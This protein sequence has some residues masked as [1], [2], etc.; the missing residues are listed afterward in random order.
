METPIVEQS[1]PA[2]QRLRIAVV[3]ETFPPEINGVAMTIGRMVVGLHQRGHAIQLVRPKQSAQDRP[4]TGAGF[5]VVRVRGV[6]IPRYAGLKLGLPAKR[7]LLRLW[8]KWRPDVVHVVT[9]GPLGWSA[10]A[11]ARRLN[12]PVTSDFHTNFHSYSRHYGIGWLQR[13]IAGYL[14]AFHNRADVTFVPTAALVRELSATG[15][16]HLKVIARGVDTAQFR[17]ERRSRELRAAWGV[18]DDGFAVIHVG[19]I[20]AEKNL[21]LLLRAFAAI[22]ERRPDARLILVGDGPARA[23]L[24]NTAPQ[25][26][27]AGMRIGGDL[28]E[29]YASGDLFLFP[30][31]TETYGNVVTEAM[32]SGL[33]VVAFDCAAAAEL[34]QPGTNGV[35]AP[36]GV[37]CAFVDAAAAVAADRELIARLGANARQRVATLDWEHINEAFAAALAQVVRTHER[38]L[39]AR[40]SF[41]MAPD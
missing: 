26:V 27:F 8:A 37:S 32:A 21:P 12:L 6:P 23:E 34:I 18:G 11:A 40:H 33:A 10:I 1:D 17:P 25:H 14:R 29:H 7:S 20:A 24:Q 19:R 16:R 35:T 36:P 15:L 3:T 41:V 5:E 22:R 2:P 13:P 4:R 9:E 38:K 39:H 30:S 31:L 28:A